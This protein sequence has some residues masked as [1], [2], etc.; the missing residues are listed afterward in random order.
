MIKI[1]FFMSSRLLSK[2]IKKICNIKE[3]RYNQYEISKKLQ[4]LKESAL[5]NNQNEKASQIWCLQEAVL[6]HTNYFSAFSNLKN[7]NFYEAWCDLELVEKGLWSIT[8]PQT[9]LPDYW[10]EVWIKGQYYFI[11]EHTSKW[12]KLYPYHL[13]CSTEETFKEYCSVCNKE[14]NPR[15]PCGHKDGEIYNGEMRMRVLK[16]IKIHALSLVENPAR[17]FSV[18][19]LSDPQSGDTID[20]YDY[21]LV[22]YLSN[23]LNHPFQKW[24]Y[25]ITTIDRDYNYFKSL[26]ISD[27][28]SCPCESGKK[29]KDCCINTTIA[30]PHYQFKIEPT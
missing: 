8:P 28:D 11:E 1:Q 21:K 2:I 4:N 9:H 17:K 23:L 24:D 22:R 20:H 3:N 26:G 6:V 25:E 16:D 18:P 13:F 10:S 15:K 30:T 19:F 12:Q 5:R 27:E 29:Y 7:H 14:I